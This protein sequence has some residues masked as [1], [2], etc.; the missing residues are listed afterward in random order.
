M[1]VFKKKKKIGIKEA[2]YM[3]D[4]QEKSWSV[5]K[6]LEFTETVKLANNET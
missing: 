2:G 3:T 4:H 5:A 1:S 6:E